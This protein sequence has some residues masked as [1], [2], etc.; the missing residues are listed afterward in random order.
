MG[1][2]SSFDL[3]AII[4]ELNKTIRGSRINKIYQVNPKTIL[5]RLR[6]QSE[7]FNLLMEAGRRI[8]LTAYEVEKPE[9]PP[10]FCMA[11][12]KFLENGI[13][14]DIS[15][16][17]LER[18]A[19]LH[20]KRGDQKYRLIVELFER[21]NIVLV[22][23]ENRIIHAL[24]YRRMRDRNILRGE[25]YKYPPQ[26]GIDPRKAK[27][28]DLY[29][30]RDL[31]E[32]ETVRSLTRLLGISGSYAEEIL[33]R[34]GVD[35]TKP[36]SS[37]SDEEINAIFNSM[38]EILHEISSGSYRP[39]IV[40]DANGNWVDVAPFPLKKYF[41][42][43]F[44]EFETFNKALDEYYSKIIYQEEV[45]V[46]EERIKQKILKLEKILEEQRRNLREL[47]EK[48]QR[49]RLVGDIIF[50]HLHEFNA[51]IEKIMEEKKRGRKWEDIVEMI[52]REKEKGASPSIYFV[53]LDSKELTLR[54]SVDGQTFNLN[55]R[56]SA[57]ENATKYYEEAKRVREKAE[58]IKRAIEDTLRKIEEAKS[59]VS[60]STE[61]ISPPKLV[62]KKEWYEKFRWFYSSEGFLV[63]GGR[64]ASTN[65]ALI[66]KYLEDH[67]IIFHADIPG[68]PF[69]IIK[70]YG[71]RPG[72]ET[73]FEAAQ[74]TASYSR[75][76]KENMGAMDVYWVKPEQISK[77]PPSGQYLP[78]GS[79]MIYGTR[80]YIKN[81][82][83]EV[84]I[85]I[86]RENGGIRVIGGPASAISKQT[87]LYVKIVPGNVPSGRLAKLIREKLASMAPPN[88]RKAILET[89]LEDIQAF[90]PLGQGSIA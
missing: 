43:N 31:G 86:K 37:L 47:E 33:F 3:V 77:A 45:K 84:A 82:P 19:E 72:E 50:S 26:R 16:Y 42:F 61:E 30:L 78:R 58:G 75:A 38:N 14:E 51:L 34:A 17:D 49:C 69:T 41:K 62:R 24:I 9:R 20:I 74:F 87:N 68:S 8:H 71:R 7:T 65:E 63:I 10:S 2:I 55:L 5:I 57:Q 36:C 46:A 25:E 76:W 28:E 1:G 18:I 73:I 64:D 15:Q 60:E 32:V 80:N 88:E 11:L 54:V 83:L 89:P 66:R 52:S 70:T 67:D 40:V 27:L 79:F 44:I 21:G 85:G 29:K 59:E 90:I 53:S 6:G 39:C 56:A 12:R 81:V 22:D 48:A 4:T 23:S 35:K 13:L